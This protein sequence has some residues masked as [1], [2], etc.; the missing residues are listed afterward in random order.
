MNENEIRVCVSYGKKKCR[1]YH[2]FNFNSTY[3]CTFMKT[4][5]DCA[6]DDG[7]VSYLVLAYCSFPLELIWLAIILLAIWLFVL[8]VAIGA[9]TDSF[10]C[11]S[12][13]VIA[14]TMRLS[15]NIAGV[16]FLAFG[17]GAPDVFSAIAAAT[18]SK[19]GDA[20]LVFGALFGAGVFVTTVVVGIICLVTPF[21]SVQRPL[22]RDIIFFMVAGFWAFVMIWDGEITLFETLGFLFLYVIYIVV[23]V[24]GRYVNQRIKLKTLGA[25]AVA[26]NDFKRT[27]PNCEAQLSSPHTHVAVYEEAEASAEDEMEAEGLRKPLLTKIINQPIPDVELTYYNSLTEAVSGFDLKE[28]HDSTFLFKIMVIIKVI[29]LTF[30]LISYEFESKTKHCTI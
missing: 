5:D 24:L 3:L 10:F 8:F 29:I 16:T 15:Q 17:N 20:G 1:D 9:T 23:V 14:D 22:L 18:N 2:R 28:W 27:A 11:P 4:N 30:H 26:K 25:E 12:L 6:I 7:F 13:R 19:D 21:T